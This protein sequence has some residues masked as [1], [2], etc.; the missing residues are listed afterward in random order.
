[1]AMTYYRR[2]DQENWSQSS[3]EPPWGPAIACFFDQIRRR[4]WI[5]AVCALFGATLGVVGKFVMPVKYEAST[6]LLFDPRGFKLFNNDLTIGNYDANAA[7]NFVESQM[8]VL[9]SERV[10]SRL[11]QTACFE[12]GKADPQAYG[13]AGKCPKTDAKGDWDAVLTQ[14]RRALVVKRAERSFLVEVTMSGPSPW[15]A[16]RRASG[17]V[18][19]YIEEDAATRNDTAA[20]LTADLSGRLDTLRAALAQS[21]AKAER[22]R[23]DKNLV[24]VGDRLLVEQQLAAATAALNDS[25]IK[26]DRASARVKQ[27]E[28][29][30]QNPNALGA[31]GADTDT[32]TLLQLIEQR[33]KAMVELAPL[34]AR[35][36]ARHPA[37][38]AARSAVAQIERAIA[39]EMRA[40]KVAA[41]A[42]VSRARNEQQILAS[43]V[44]AL[45]DKVTHARQSEIELREISQEVDANRKLLDTFETRSREAK[46]FGRIDTGNL[47]IVSMARPPETQRLA[48]KMA[49]FGGLGMFVGII[50]GFAIL[51]AMT[52]VAM[53]RGAASLPRQIARPLPAFYMPIDVPVNFG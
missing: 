22:Y 9:Q 6:Q 48:P 20:R 18:T 24:R 45:S 7:I 40:M 47:R 37:L 8:G 17:I 43:T 44:S 26:F 41:R 52:F 23:R 3:A 51:A 36:G 31:L 4:Y 42:D 19:A 15:I 13:L 34:A 50:L 35:L 1:M 10:L 12:T 14:L 2:I 39:T 38:V 53:L 25:Q 33:N 27:M 32:R 28:A 11:V 49:I 16:A 29:V 5:L 30:A 46:E 21:E